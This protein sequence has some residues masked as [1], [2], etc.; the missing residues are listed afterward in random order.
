MKTKNMIPGE[1]EFFK[2]VIRQISYSDSSFKI[3]KNND[4]YEIVIKAYFNNSLGQIAQKYVK[5]INKLPPDDYTHYYGMWSKKGIL[6]YDYFSLNYNSAYMVISSEYNKFYYNIIP[7]R[8][9]KHLGIDKKFYPSHIQNKKEMGYYESDFFIFINTYFYNTKMKEDDNNLIIT[10]NRSIRDLI[11]EYHG[12]FKLDNIV[13]AKNLPS[14]NYLRKLIHRWEHQGIL[15]VYSDSLVFNLSL[16]SD[17]Y[18]LC[19][20]SSC[21]NIN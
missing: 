20:F 6:R 12:V 21:T 7:Y 18:Y 15:T 14:R 2:F 11:Y 8:V 1:M 19:D 3:I 4:D 17:K 5:K 10:I 13:I 9:L 16:S